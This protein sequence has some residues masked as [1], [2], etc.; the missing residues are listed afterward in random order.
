MCLPPPEIIASI[1]LHLPVDSNLKNILSIPLFASFLSDPWF[2]RK[3]IL[4]FESATPP[5]QLVA[6]KDLPF[7]YKL[8]LWKTSFETNKFKW[9]CGDCLANYGNVTFGIVKRTRLGQCALA[10]SHQKGHDAI[11][12]LK[13]VSLPS[14]IPKSNVFLLWLVRQQAK[15]TVL[16]HWL[17]QNDGRSPQLSLLESSV[18]SDFALFYAVKNGYLEAAKILLSHHRVILSLEGQT[19]LSKL[20]NDLK[21]IEITEILA[22]R[23][24]DSRMETAFETV[25]IAVN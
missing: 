13:L 23:N 9:T 22:C 18:N 6:S 21:Y 15:T 3:H 19:K 8:E 14:F 1:L 12:P 25:T 4:Q 10:E 11:I 24:Q 17:R 7:L 20:A 16:T 2:I 5:N